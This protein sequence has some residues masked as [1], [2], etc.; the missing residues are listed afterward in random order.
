MQPRPDEECKCVDS[1]LVKWARPG[2]YLSH[3]FTPCPF[4]SI[5]VR[6]PPLLAPLPHVVVLRWRPGPDHDRRGQTAFEQVPSQVP[7]PHPSTQST[8][9]T[10]PSSKLLP[11]LPGT[12]PGRRIP[13]K[14]RS[15]KP[16]FRIKPFEGLNFAIHSFGIDWDFV[17]K[18]C[19]V[20]FPNNPAPFGCPKS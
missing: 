9:P 3:S 20:A 5:Q 16:A 13:K 7:S 14:E 1:E 8:P 15:W 12:L 18:Q 4:L 19:S 17:S 2:L 6:S 10:M 11:L